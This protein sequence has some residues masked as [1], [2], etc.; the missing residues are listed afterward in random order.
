MA[1]SM[2]TNSKAPLSEINV[3]PLVDVMLVLLIIFMVTAPMMQEGISVNLPQAKGSPLEEREEAKKITIIVSAQGK[4]LVNDVVVTEEELPAR[5]LQ[6]TSSDPNVEVNLRA[7][8]GVQYG[9]VV[10][11]IAAL[12]RAGIARLGM[13]TSPQEE[14][15]S[16]Q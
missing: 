11:V 1:F 9:I 8:K 10:R 2:N 3:T 14:S 16:G 15:V 12:T 13:I 5:L 6:T 4:I 7:D